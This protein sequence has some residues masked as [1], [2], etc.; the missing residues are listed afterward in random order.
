MPI[1][2]ITGRS[3][4]LAVAAL[5]L[6]I[7]AT[8]S[9]GTARAATIHACVKPGSG[10]TRIVGAKA[11]CHHGEQKLSWSSSGPAGPNGAAGANGTAGAPGPE[12]KA[13]PTGSS[14]LYTALDFESKTISTGETTVLNKTLPPG[15]FAVSAKT[16]IVAE[17]ST[18]A[19]TEGLCVLTDRP[20]TTGVGEA[21]QL[22]ISAWAGGLGEKGTNEFEADSALVLQGFLISKVTS[23][24][25]MVCLNIKAPVAKAAITQMQALTVSSIA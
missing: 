20:G 22:D 1:T 11:K 24:L 8:L 14:A 10:A 7:L 17:A 19:F 2:T 25:S 9:T 5:A 12:G 16:T 15:S 18:Q 21:A 13:G 4:L 6:I 23:T 3:L